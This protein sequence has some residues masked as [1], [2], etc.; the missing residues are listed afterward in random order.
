[1]TSLNSLLTSQLVLFQS[2]IPSLNFIQ[3]NTRPLSHTKELSSQQSP[4]IEDVAQMEHDNSELTFNESANSDSS[5]IPSL[6]SDTGRL[7]VV[8]KRNSV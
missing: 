3:P 1:M 5:S 7:H 4:D 8:L 2:P 6:N